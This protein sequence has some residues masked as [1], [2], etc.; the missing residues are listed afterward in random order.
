[1][2]IIVPDQYVFH[3]NFLLKLLRI[4]NIVSIN[5]PI[6]PELLQE[7]IDYYSALNLN[8]NVGNLKN[9]TITKVNELSELSDQNTIKDIEQDVLIKLGSLK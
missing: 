5:K 4:D 1:M 3:I 9:L 8:I 7:T 2:D 6:N